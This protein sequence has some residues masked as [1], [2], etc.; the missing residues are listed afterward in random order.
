MILL[1]PTTHCKTSARVAYSSRFAPTQATLANALNVY[2][3]H[4]IITA[5][6]IKQAH[7]TI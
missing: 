5:L 1:T 3:E 6:K 2:L 4:F 7:E